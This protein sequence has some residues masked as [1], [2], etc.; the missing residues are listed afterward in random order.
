MQHSYTAI[1]DKQNQKPD[2]H[3]YV[4]FHIS[5]DNVASVWAELQ[6]EN[7]GSKILVEVVYRPH[8]QRAEVMGGNKKPML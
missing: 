6:R 3:I 7:K 8:L 5:S 4:R 1:Y 2:G